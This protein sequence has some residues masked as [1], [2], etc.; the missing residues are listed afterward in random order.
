V[1]VW[2]RRRRQGIARLTYS[3]RVGDDGDAR[4]YTAETAAAPYR[5]DIQPGSRVLVLYDA[6]NP[7]LSEIDR[8][9]ARPGDHLRLL[10]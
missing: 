10:P 1:E 7:C 9:D 5:G 8:F 2:R 3:Y 4:E 6:E